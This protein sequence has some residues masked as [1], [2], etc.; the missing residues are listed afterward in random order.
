MQQ[1]AQSNAAAPATVPSMEGQQQRK[2]VVTSYVPR[3]LVLSPHPK[4]GRKSVHRSG[5][6]SQRGDTLCIVEAM[7]MMNQIEADKSV[8]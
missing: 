1:P 7:K 4:P 2:S 8:P 3:W 5:S 6:E